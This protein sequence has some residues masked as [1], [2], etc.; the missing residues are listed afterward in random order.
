MISKLSSVSADAKID[1]SVIVEPFTTIYEDV[2]I[3]ENTK[4]GP[5]VTIYPGTRIG[6][7]CE[8]FPG[9]VIGVIPQ[10]LKFQGEY[11]TVEIGDNT[12]IRECVTIHR[13]TE[14]K[15]KTVVGSNCLIMGYVHIAHDCI[16]GNNVILANYTGLS[17]HCQI[18]DFA[19]LEGKVAAQQFMHI[20]AHAFV[21]GASLV[22]KNVPPFV[23]AA[24]EPLSYAGV[25]SVGLRRRGFSDESIKHIEDIYRILFVQNNNISKGIDALKTEL[26][27]TAH[28]KQVI[29]FIESCEKGIIRG[30]L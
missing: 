21:A 22:R 8:I 12:K 4:I 26:P 2:I 3:G 10:D 6:K 11:T 1:E 19:I 18:D 24:R 17:G 5:N 15:K 20:G 27:E 7:N 13:G 16:I 30:L 28:R 29:D 23:R 9:S 25:N 14:D